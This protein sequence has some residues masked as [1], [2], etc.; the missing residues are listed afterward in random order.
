M[1]SSCSG[2]Q[3]LES[4]IVECFT[5]KPFRM[6]LFL[7]RFDYIDLGFHERDLLL[8]RIEFK[9]KIFTILN[10]VLLFDALSC[11]SCV[12]FFFSFNIPF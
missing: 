12:S 6:S 11:K 2:R 7:I 4:L 3:R 1:F 8:F 10:Q 5:K 9:K